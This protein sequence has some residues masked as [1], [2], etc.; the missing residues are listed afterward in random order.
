MGGTGIRFTTKKASISPTYQEKRV[1]HNKGPL[2][3]FDTTNQSS[4]IMQIFALAGAKPTTFYCKSSNAMRNSN[5]MAEKQ[6]VIDGVSQWES[7]MYHT[8]PRQ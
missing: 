1:W 6:R 8:L 5:A 7:A 3:T 2:H 4:R